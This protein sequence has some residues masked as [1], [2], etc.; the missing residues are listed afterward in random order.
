LFIRATLWG[1]AMPLKGQTLSSEEGDGKLPPL[2]SGKL[3]ESEQRGA[4]LGKDA[5]PSPIWVGPAAHPRLSLRFGCL[6][7][8]KICQPWP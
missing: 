7:G 8:I 3:A 2:A 1:V 6:K 5:K 4:P